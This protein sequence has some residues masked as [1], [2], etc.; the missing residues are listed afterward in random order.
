MQKHESCFITLHLIGFGKTAQ[1]TWMYKNHPLL[2]HLWNQNKL[3]ALWRALHGLAVWPFN[4]KP[5]VLLGFTGLLH[6]RGGQGGC[7]ICLQKHAIKSA[8]GGAKQ[9]ENK[10]EKT[11][12][13]SPTLESLFY[14]NFILFLYQF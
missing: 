10:P 3:Q 1:H 2:A 9:R 8:T 11:K 14:I 7:D 6:T 5:S 4:D 13:C 12:S